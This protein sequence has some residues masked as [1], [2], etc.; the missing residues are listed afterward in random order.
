ML[1]PLFSPSFWHPLTSKTAP[2]KYSAALASKLG[3]PRM[4]QP[5]F[6]P[7]MASLRLA[8]A[9]LLVSNICYGYILYILYSSRISYSFLCINFKTTCIYPIVPT[10]HSNIDKHIVYDMMYA[11]SGGAHKSQ[12]F[13][14][15]RFWSLANWDGIS[16]YPYVGGSC[17]GYVSTRRYHW[18]H[19]PPH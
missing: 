7:H 10:L 8:R 5:W 19:A 4:L 13:C 12:C 15:L 11:A 9:K 16:V 6:L 17:V 1:K 14:K 18:Q 3:A 2:P